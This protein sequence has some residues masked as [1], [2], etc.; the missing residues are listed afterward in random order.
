MIKVEI[1]RKGNTKQIISE[2]EKLKTLNLEAVGEVV[3]QKLIDEIDSQRKRDVKKKSDR[4]KG[5]YSKHLKDIIKVVVTSK[6]VGIGNIAELN[7]FTPY[8]KLLN[9][10]GKVPG[11]THG[12]FGDNFYPGAPGY[13]TQAFKYDKKGPLM[14]PMKAIEGIQ[15][16]EKTLAWTNK[17]LSKF[18]KQLVAKNSKGTIKN[19]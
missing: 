8:W 14:Q 19:K 18:I 15:Y 5:K 6:G 2:L 3:R 12:F 7:K 11:P 4:Y 16:I 9:D 17:N 13:S 1:L 10:G